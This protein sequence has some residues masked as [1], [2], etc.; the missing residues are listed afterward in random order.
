MP[1]S[2]S[3]IYYQIR[4]PNCVIAILAKKNPI[5][6]VTHCTL[7]FCIAYRMFK[8]SYT[9]LAVWSDKEEDWSGEL[10]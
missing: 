4:Y 2:C 6:L 3:E 10:G 8:A 5:L 1:F 9:A 7:I